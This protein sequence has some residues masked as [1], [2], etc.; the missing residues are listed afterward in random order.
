MYNARRRLAVRPSHLFE[1][2]VILAIAV[3]LLT[4]ACGRETSDVDSPAG[5]ALAVAHSDGISWE[6]DWDAA[7]ERARSDDRVVLVDVYADWCVW[8]R[9]LDSTTYRDQRVVSFVT[10]EMVPIKVN[11]DRQGSR[12][13]DLGVSG[14]P[15]ILV[16]SSDGRELGRIPGYLPAADFM[17]AIREIVEKA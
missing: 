10:A 14:L 8:C 11:A 16:L 1:I 3:G 5:P 4:G 9:R 17:D 12:V 6:T 7:F 2:W 13:D 15:T